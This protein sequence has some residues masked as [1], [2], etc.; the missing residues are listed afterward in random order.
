MHWPVSLLMAAAAV[1]AEWLV[2]PGHPRFGLVQGIISLV[3]FF[4]VVLILACFSR[5]ETRTRRSF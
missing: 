2:A 3:I 5:L 4:A 1:A